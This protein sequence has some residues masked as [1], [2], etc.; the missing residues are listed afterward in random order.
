VTTEE[1]SV[2]TQLNLRFRPA[3]LSYF[4]R[5]VPDH[6]EAEDLA[7]EVLIRLVNHCE[8]APDAAH[9]Y[10]FQTAANLLRDRARRQKVRTAYAASIGDLPDREVDTLDPH[11]HAEA[12]FE[13]R[14]LEQ[15]IAALPERMRSILL[16]YRFEGVGKQMIADSLGVSL[17]TVE[18]DIALAMAILAGKLG[19]SR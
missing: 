17:S 18:K 16:L 10:V 5:R 11:R 3:L 15:H 7:Q 6:M 8:V 9:A 19:R 2:M 12:R 13:L 14:A 4:R 1:V